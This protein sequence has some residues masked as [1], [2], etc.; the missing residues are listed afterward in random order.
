MKLRTF[1]N[2]IL[3]K[4][5]GGGIVSLCAA[6]LLTFCAKDELDSAKLVRIGVPQQ[7]SVGACLSQV[8]NPDKTTINSD[9]YV[10]WE[11]TDEIIVNNSVIGGI[12]INPTDP[13]WATFEGMAGAIDETGY[14]GIFPTSIAS[15][16][17]SDYQ[18]NS[19]K[20]TLPATQTF[21]SEAS[22]LPNCM[23]AYRE[24]SGSLINLEFKNLCC[25]VKIP[26]K[27]GT[28]S[29]SPHSTITRMEFSSSQ[30]LSGTASVSWN[31]GNPS[32]AFASGQN[33]VT[34]DLGSGI[35][36]GSD[37][38]VFSVMLPPGERTLTVRFYDGRGGG[39]KYME[40][41]VTA[42]FQR[43][44]IYTMPVVEFNAQ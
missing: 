39:S 5:A 28:H 20:V 35:S 42:N 19:I 13:T 41:I 22:S 15:R 38:T 8:E 34:L 31:N 30:N 32:M 21:T 7:V 4:I 6:M 14:W 29:A 37:P 40:K 25:F 2:P 11:G 18:K 1:K 17:A 27:V 23:V 24:T 36:I 16:T 44:T 12:S 26:I 43:S 3:S 9:G 33:T 10:H